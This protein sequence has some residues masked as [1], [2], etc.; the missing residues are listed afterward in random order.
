MENVY[1]PKDVCKIFIDRYTSAG[2]NNKR[3]ILSSGKDTLL[4]HCVV[5]LLSL[6]QYT[7]SFSKL[8]PEVSTTDQKLN[9]VCKALGCSVKRIGQTGEKIVALTSPPKTSTNSPFGSDRK[10][11]RPV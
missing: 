2:R 9:S 1:I 3:T 8:L 4:A 11:K 10:R 7:F 6:N 5:L